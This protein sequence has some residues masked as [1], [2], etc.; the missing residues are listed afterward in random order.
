MEEA[1]AGTST[2]APVEGIE[3]AIDIDI[4]VDNFINDVDPIGAAFDP[5]TPNTV[6]EVPTSIICNQSRSPRDKSIKD[7][8]NKEEAFDEGYDS[9]GRMGPFHNRTDK[10]GPQLFNKDDDD[11][12]G[13]VAERRID[14]ERDVDTDVADDIDDEVHV[15]ILLDEINKINMIELKNELKLRQQSIYGAK[16][17]LKERLIKALDKKLPKYSLEYLAKKKTT[18]TEAKKRIQHK[19][20]LLFLKLLSGRN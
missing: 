2:V 4:D 19:A 11:G 17:K 5:R 7:V 18:D 1:V 13:V 15:P 8:K 9:D 20:C 16:F 3:S 6:V 10:E 12:V 14:D